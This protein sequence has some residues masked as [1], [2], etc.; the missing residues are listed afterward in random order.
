MYGVDGSHLRLQQPAVADSPQNLRPVH[1]RLFPMP[2]AAEANLYT[3]FQ[4][5]SLLADPDKPKEPQKLLYNGYIQTAKKNPRNITIDGLQNVCKF[6]EQWIHSNL[7]WQLRGCMYQCSA[8]I[9][10]IL[11]HIA[12]CDKND[13]RC[14]TVKK[15]M[16]HFASCCR[17][18]FVCGP[19]YEAVFKP[20]FC[21]R[22]SPVLFDTETD[23]MRPTKFPRVDDGGQLVDV[24]RRYVHQFQDTNEQSTV[25]NNQRRGNLYSGTEVPLDPQMSRFA[26]FSSQLTSEQVTEMNWMQTQGI[27]QMEVYRVDAVDGSNPF[28]NSHDTDN[29][30]Q[31]DHVQL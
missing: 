29:Y 15:W 11:Q 31:H 4:A 1:N 19:I 2:T 17:N 28:Y 12:K 3:C 14:I 30:S 23:V 5:R 25:N 13:C 9:A 6:L 7:Q 21:K 26:P 10:R 24:V 22:K 8:R 18:C 16:G 27:N 20:I